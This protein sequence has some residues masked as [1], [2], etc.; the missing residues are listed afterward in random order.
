MHDL[1]FVSLDTIAEKDLIDLM[2]DPAVGRLLP[3]LRGR[4]GVEECRAFQAAKRAL[5]EQH[6]YGPW[7]FCI[8]GEFAGWGG[9]QPE[10]G[11]ADFALILHPRFWGWGRR[12]FMAVKQRAFGEMKLPFITA[13]LPP[14]RTNA[15]AIRRFG[16]VEDG[17][18]EIEGNTFR[19]FRL[20]AEPAD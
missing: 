1:A 13:L 10:R 3:L 20:D 6:G 15:G 12:I 2:N 16:F 9:L 5:W 14:G 19:R 8:N 4:F 11:E 7:A 18:V 17:N